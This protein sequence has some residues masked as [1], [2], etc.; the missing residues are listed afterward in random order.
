MVYSAADGQVVGENLLSTGMPLEISAT[1][2]LRSKSIAD[3]L[4]TD[5]PG[6][7]SIAVG[8]EVEQLPERRNRSI[9]LTNKS[10]EQNHLMGIGRL[11]GLMN[12]T[13]T[14]IETSKDLNAPAYVITA[15]RCVQPQIPNVVFLDGQVGDLHVIFNLFADTQDNQINIPAKSIAYSTMKGRDLAIV[16]LDETVGGLKSKGLEPFVLNEELIEESSPITM[17]SAPIVGFPKEASFLRM[18]RCIFNEQVD[19]IESNLITYDAMQTDC[20]DNYSGSAGSPILDESN[21]ELLGVSSST[22]IA[23]FSPCSLGA[24]CEV[25]P[26][27]VQMRENA[28][29]A[30]PLDGVKECFDNTGRFDIALE[31]CGLDNGRQFQLSNSLGE[32]TQSVYRPSA[33]QAVQ[34]SWNTNVSGDY[35]YYRYKIGSVSQTNCRVEDNYGPP[36]RVNEGTVIDEPLPSEDG[37]FILCVLGGDSPDPRDKGLW[38]SPKFVTTDLIKV[39]N[40]SPI[41][42]PIVAIVHEEAFYSVYLHPSPP[43]LSYYEIKLGSEADVDCHNDDNYSPVPREGL[44]IT[45]NNPNKLCVIAFDSAGNKGLPFEYIIGQEQ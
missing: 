16:Q 10:G 26:E 13:S 30:T 28:S 8:L 5:L 32:V 23:G 15:G 29:Y 40:T 17:I 3:I 1:P 27:N 24:P 19:L 33:D 4:T 39:D 42:E 11:F 2:T 44:Q 43:E 31:G 45:K 25:E 34:V 35:L 9:L 14:F 36:I 20:Q 38:Q 41:L 22:T 12:C 37:I 6:Q 18:E 7:N 21:T